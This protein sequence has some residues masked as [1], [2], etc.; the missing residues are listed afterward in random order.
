MNEPTTLPQQSKPV[1]GVALLKQALEKPEY[2][3]ALARVLKD[4]APQF[5]SSL[6][7]LV[8][9]DPRLAQCDPKSIIAAAMTPAILDL[10][11]EKNLGFAWI[12]AYKDKTR[13]YVAQFQMGFRG[14]IQLAMRTGQYKAMNA[15]SVNDGA[16]KGWD[17]MGEPVI[18]WSAIDDTKPAVGYVFAFKL[19]SGFTKICYWTKAKVEAHAQRYSQSYR[20]GGESPWKTHPEAM[21]LKTLIKNELAKWGILSVQ[22]QRALT[23][24]QAIRRDINA[25]PEYIDVPTEV[26]PQQS[27]LLKPG[28]PRKLAPP[29][30][31]PPPPPAA[32]AEPEPQSEPAPSDDDV[33]G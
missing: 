2:T 3:A 33:L 22:M 26:E 17:D 27:R 8:S 23:D 9:G 5:A 25:E 30:D 16:F 28:R 11:I 31:T 10:P 13:G 20:G 4:R 6:V 32:E 15:R 1:S 24:D 18:D 19:V 21:A 7:Q 14:Y 29:S 12:V